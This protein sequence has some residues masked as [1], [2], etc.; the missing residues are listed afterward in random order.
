[1]ITQLETASKYPINILI[2]SA[3]LILTSLYS[4]DHLLTCYNLLTCYDY[5]LLPIPSPSLKHKPHE[6]GDLHLAS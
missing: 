3:V 2:P 6:S 4:I 1:M 5:C